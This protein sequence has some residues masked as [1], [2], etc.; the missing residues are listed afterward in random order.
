MRIWIIRTLLKLIGLWIIC[1]A[2]VE[3]YVTSSVKLRAI[4]KKETKPVSGAIAG[5]FPILRVSPYGPAGNVEQHQSLLEKGSFA[6]ESNLGRKERSIPIDSLNFGS[7]S[8]HSGVDGNTSPPLLAR[9]TTE[10]KDIFISVKTTSSNHKRLDLILDTWYIMA[11]DQ[12]WLI[13]GAIMLVT[14]LTAKVLL[15][16]EVD[17]EPK[18]VN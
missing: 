2:A 18:V 1:F 16:K 10:L 4:F 14:V 15:I 8:R 5:R 11:R 7:K 17:T 6:N 13:Y 3:L 12:V 9:R